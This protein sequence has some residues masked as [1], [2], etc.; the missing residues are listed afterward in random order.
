MC[1]SSC[2]SL[3]SHA[4]CPRIEVLLHWSCNTWVRVPDSNYGDDGDVV[5]NTMCLIHENTCMVHLETLDF[6][7]NVIF[8]SHS[9]SLWEQSDQKTKNTRKHFYL[10][11]HSRN[12]VH[13]EKTE[14]LKIWKFLGLLMHSWWLK[15]PPDWS[16]GW[17]L[18][19]CHEAA[20]AA[21][22]CERGHRWWRT[23]QTSAD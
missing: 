15:N 10:I 11:C 4:V 2:Q 13:F 18:R 21:C 16:H 19:L 14:L 7:S 22:L 3:F 8:A 9:F 6:C 23:R 17:Y 5:T 1:V 12:W 20:R